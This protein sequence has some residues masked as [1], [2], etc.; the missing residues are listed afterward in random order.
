MS[1]QNRTILITGASR[2]IGEAMAYRFA[3]DGANIVVAAKTSEPHPS[4]PGTIHTVA[5]E[6]EKR[7]GRAL[8][9]Q[10]DVREEDQVMAAVE[11]TVEVFGGIDILVNNASAIFPTGTLDTPM[12]RFDLMVSCN[13][14][15]TFL[16]SKACIPYLKKSGN[17]HILNLSPPLSM[18]PKWFKGHVAYTMSKYGMSM[19]TIGMA[20]EFRKEGIAVN[21]LWPQTTIATQA[22]QVFFPF[23]MDKSRKPSIM[24]DAAYY[25]LTQESRSLTGQCLIDEEILLKAGIDDFEKYSQTPGQELQPDLFVET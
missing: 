24:A 12:K 7:G 22:I 9:L 10:V 3:E 16:C 14:R 8:P 1:L 15:G 11:K 21:S 25:I 2:G 5:E 13:M 19:C 18:D 20:E 17:P 23:L 4:L 6:I